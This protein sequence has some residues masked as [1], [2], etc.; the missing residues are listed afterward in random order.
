MKIFSIA[1]VPHEVEEAN[2]DEKISNT[3]I[4]VEITTPIVGLPPSCK[5]IQC[6]VCLT[7]NIFASLS[8]FL[9]LRSQSVAK[10]TKKVSERV[11]ASMN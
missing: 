5:E 10:N 4:P 3:P 2:N 1:D 7:P 6:Q 11:H 9:S 8:H